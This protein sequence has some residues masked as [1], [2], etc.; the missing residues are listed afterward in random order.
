VQVRRVPTS[1]LAEDFKKLRFGYRLV[2]LWACRSP[3]DGPDQAVASSRGERHLKREESGRRGELG[4]PQVFKFGRSALSAAR[5][6]Q[7]ADD[8]SPLT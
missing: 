8:V 5:D 2:A 1:S 7:S 4:N 6:L 3:T